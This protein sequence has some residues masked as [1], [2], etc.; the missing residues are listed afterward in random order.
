MH[1]DRQ[2]C[3]KTHG[4]AGNLTDRHAARFTDRQAG[5]QAGRQTH[6]ETKTNE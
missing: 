3:R 1:A 5:R 2:T 4:Q 6:I